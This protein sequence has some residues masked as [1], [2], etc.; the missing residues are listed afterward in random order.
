MET[1]TIYKATNTF[2]NKV[3]IGFTTTWPNRINTHYYDSQYDK[4][5]KAFY[6]AIKKYG[7]EAF[8]WEAI[9]Q[10]LDREH[11]LK[12]MEPHFITEYRS[13]VGFDNS[14]GY[15]ITLGGEGTF[16]WK[17]PPELIERHREK[18]KGRKQTEEHVRKRMKS[19]DSNPLWHLSLSNRPP[20]TLQTREKISV[21]H[22]GKP[23]SEAHILA[24][25]SRPQD[26]TS[27]ACPHCGQVGDYKN[28]KRWH[29]DYCKKNPERDTKFDL[30]TVQCEQ[31]GHTAK[32]SPNFRRYHGA[33]CKS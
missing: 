1:Y 28:M 13:W 9:Y 17:R 2:N 20:Q 25:R 23:K 6:N 27:L 19:R 21:A 18:M 3:Y 26:T 7:W 29:F 24:M 30:P 4:T 31:C 22:K 32:Q 5:N 15:N 11:T 33:N 16:G 14:N 12:T 10:S 8:T